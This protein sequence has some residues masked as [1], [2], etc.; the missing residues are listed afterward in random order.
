MAVHP[1]IVATDLAKDFFI[2]EVPKALRPIVLPA[3]RAALFPLF[4]R[5]CKLAAETVRH[6]CTAPDAEVAGEYVADG[7]VAWSSAESNDSLLAASLWE[8]GRELT[9]V[10]D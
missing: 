7:A 9:S 3:C 4:L 2:N 5:P 10:S 1:G 8:L 6:A